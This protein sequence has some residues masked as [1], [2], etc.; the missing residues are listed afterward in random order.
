M[1]FAA[2]PA[3]RAYTTIKR[4]GQNDF[5]LRIGAAFQHA[6]RSG[7]NV[8]LQGLPIDGRIVLRL[9]SETENTEEAE[10]N[11]QFVRR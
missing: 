8:V 6:N 5:W 10:R 4:D 7:L 11:R 1:T 2:K 9:P 3:F